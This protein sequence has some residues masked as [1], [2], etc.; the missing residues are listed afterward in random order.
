MKIENY[1][2]DL[3]KVFML[4]IEDKEKVHDYYRDMLM[5]SS[6]GSYD[7]SNSLMLTL[8]NGGYLLEVRD[9]KLKK[10]LDE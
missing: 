3:N 5:F 9:E 10:I 6:Q 8:F 2:L 7:M 1:Y 4:N